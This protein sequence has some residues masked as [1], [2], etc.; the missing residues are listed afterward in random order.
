MSQHNYQIQISS[1]CPVG[2]SIWIYMSGYGLFQFDKEN[3][4]IKFFTELP[5]EVS[6]IGAFETIIEY[7]KKLYFIP[8]Y[9]DDIYYYDIEQNCFQMLNIPFSNLEGL[10]KR[11]I[12]STILR[13]D[14]LY[15]IIRRPFCVVCINL[16]QEKYEICFFQKDYLLP[17]DWK[18]QMSMAF[19]E[20][21][22]DK[23]SVLIP[24]ANNEIVIFDMKQK[25]FSIKKLSSLRIENVPRFP[26]WKNSIMQIEKMYSNAYFMRMYNGDIYQFDENSLTKVELPEEVSG[27]YALGDRS[28]LPRIYKFLV[29]GS[30]IYFFFYNNHDVLKFNCKNGEFLWYENHYVSQRGKNQTAPIYVEIKMFDSNTVLLHSRQDNALYLFNTDAGFIGNPSVCMTKEFYETEMVRH[31]HSAKKYLLDY[32]DEELLMVYVRKVE[33]DDMSGREKGLC[34]ACIFEQTSRDES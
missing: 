23:D 2:D 32:G 34:G 11:K 18:K 16:F 12:I 6:D 30:F 33:K 4:Q 8:C 20:V 13:D 27:Y 24:Y 26:W 22:V 29:I 17:D 28:F 31:K 15:C 14:I 19:F 7:N 5:A 3:A 10:A 9:A 25:N 1:Y 21:C